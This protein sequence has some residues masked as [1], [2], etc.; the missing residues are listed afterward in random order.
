MLLNS[1]IH[2]A[3]LAHCF[4]DS[5]EELGFLVVM[6]LRNTTVSSEAI[7][8]EIRF[9]GR[10]QA[11]SLLVDTVEATNERVVAHGHMGSLDGENI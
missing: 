5:G 6:M 3:R 7:T 11:W 4:V 10:L 9:V 2:H 1:T 8:N